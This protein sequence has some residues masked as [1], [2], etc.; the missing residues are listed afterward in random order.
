MMMPKPWNVVD[1]GWESIAQ[2]IS[3]FNPV[4]VLSLSPSCPKLVP[5]LLGRDLWFSSPL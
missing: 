3:P 5:P 4:I 1:V 2:E